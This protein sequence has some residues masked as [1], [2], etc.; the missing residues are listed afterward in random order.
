MTDMEEPLGERKVPDLSA[1]L[2][3]PGHSPSWF[4][5]QTP[6]PPALWI[7]GALRAGSMVPI[8]QM[9]ELSPNPYPECEPIFHTSVAEAGCKQVDSKPQHLV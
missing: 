2:S 7:L 4:A 3:L 5:K 8:A 6:V 9:R 1:N